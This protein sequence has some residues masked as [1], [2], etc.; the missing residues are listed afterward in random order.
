MIK[1]NFVT[2]SSHEME[3]DGMRFYGRETMRIMYRG[4]LLQCREFHDSLG[5]YGLTPLRPAK[6]HLRIRRK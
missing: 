3:I 4:V 2:F 1:Y 6:L 5:T